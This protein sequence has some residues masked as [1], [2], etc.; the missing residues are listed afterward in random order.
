MLAGL[1]D[2][3]LHGTDELTLPASWLED[4]G[5]MR[6]Y[7]AYTMRQLQQG[8]VVKDADT[9]ARERDVAHDE[10]LRMQFWQ[11]VDGKR[12]P[13]PATTGKNV[14]TFAARKKA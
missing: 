2:Y 4:K 8:T 6:S 13:A 5:R 10:A 9:I 3:L 11:R 7:T 14:A 1:L 12:Q